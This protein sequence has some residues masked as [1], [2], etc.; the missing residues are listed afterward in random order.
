[1][2]YVGFSCFLFCEEIQNLVHHNAIQDCMLHARKYSGDV[3]T[4]SVS[5]KKQQTR[6]TTECRKHDIFR[7]QLRAGPVVLA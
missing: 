1:M 4:C 7:L 3:S 5:V 2:C 6:K